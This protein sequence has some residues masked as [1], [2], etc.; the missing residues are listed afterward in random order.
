MYTVK[1]IADILD[2]SLV[3]V[4]N[5]LKKNEKE[6]KGS[7]SKKKGVTY[8]K[9]EGLK[10]LKVSLGI[11]EIPTIEKKEMTTYDLI[12]EISLNITNNVK[13]D[14]EDLKEDIKSNKDN[15][16]KELEEVKE[17][18]KVIQEQ[19]Q[20]LIELLEDKEKGFIGKLKDLF[21]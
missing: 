5:H 19:N 7:I 21:K 1:E 10:V 2:V 20:R 6:L 13:K 9:D 16:K 18:N 4:Y 17:Q 3:T 11:I 15:L 14:Y 8:I 12:D